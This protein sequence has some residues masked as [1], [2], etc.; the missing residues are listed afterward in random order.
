MRKIDRL[1]MLLFV[2]GLN[3]VSTKLHSQQIKVISA[4]S[5]GWAGGV[6]CRT[7]INYNIQLRILNPKHSLK[8]DSLWMEGYCVNISDYG[9][10][11]REKSDTVFLRLQKGVTWDEG[12]PTDNWC[13]NSTRKGVIISY[14]L[15]GKKKWLDVTP[16]IKELEFQ[17]YP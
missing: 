2:V 11:K 8:L 1:C 5:Q 10:S 12:M 6:C 3:F 17:A 15:N 14:Y 4:T 16:Y 7:G 9:I 13:F